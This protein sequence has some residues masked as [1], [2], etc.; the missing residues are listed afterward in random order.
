MLDQLPPSPMGEEVRHHTMRRARL[1]GRRG[2]GVSPA[3]GQI[4]PRV[5][6]RTLMSVMGV[7]YSLHGEHT[8]G[9]KPG[10]FWRMARK[11]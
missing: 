4:S 8:A 1:T 3:T 5:L 2:E 10:Q 11:P 6:G 7:G 9:Q